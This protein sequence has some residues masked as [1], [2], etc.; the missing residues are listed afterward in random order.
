MGNPRTLD[1]PAGQPLHHREFDFP[2]GEVFRAHTDQ[3]DAL[4]ASVRTR[5]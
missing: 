1:V 5:G 2:V 4:L 3:L